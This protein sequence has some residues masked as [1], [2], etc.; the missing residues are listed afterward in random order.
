MVVLG[1]TC[2]QSLLFPDLKAALSMWS[3]GY[4]HPP[5]S[6]KAAGIQ[7]MWDNYKVERLAVSL[8]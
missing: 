5:P 7:K 1:S 8:K 6:G 4:D 3:Q 2:L